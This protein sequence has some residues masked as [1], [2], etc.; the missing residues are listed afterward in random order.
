MA[1]EPI[2]T[3]RR[4]SDDNQFILWDKLGR[5]WQVIEEHYWENIDIPLS[6]Q[7]REDVVCRYCAVVDTI[8]GRNRVRESKKPSEQRK[9]SWC[10]LSSTALGKCCRKLKTGDKLFNFLR[11]NPTATTSLRTT[12]TIDEE[13]ERINSFKKVLGD[14][15]LF[16]SMDNA[17]YQKVRHELEQNGPL[18]GSF[19][20]Y[21]MQHL[22][23]E[24][25][26][27]TLTAYNLLQKKAFHAVVIIGWGI[28]YCKETETMELYWLAQNN[29]GPSRARYIR[30]ANDALSYICAP[31][32]EKVFQN[33]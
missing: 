1:T 15:E 25:S 23:K 3:Q 28:C 21:S 2:F 24:N 17:Q 16:C 6:S 33:R 7:V 29:W 18:Y 9:Y 11:N 4:I 30:L 14:G 32:V 26:Y 19:V 5:S 8:Y 12:G 27:Y 31:E 22:K 20:S 10:K 13:I